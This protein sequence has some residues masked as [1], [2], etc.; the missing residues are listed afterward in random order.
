MNDQKR[1]RIRALCAC[2]LAGVATLPLFAIGTTRPDDASRLIRAVE[3]DHIDTVR[4]LV[5]QGIDINARVDGDGT[6]LIAA[7]R[8]GDLMMVDTLIWMGADVNEPSVGDGNPLIA[9]AKNGHLAVAARLIAA[10]ALID[11]IV[12]DD[13]TALINAVRCSC[14]AV[15]KYLVAHGADVNLGVMADGLR[16]RTPLN[17][18]RDMTIRNFLIGSGAVFQNPPPTA[19]RTK[20][21]GSL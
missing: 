5:S 2:T 18:A 21:V 4:L 11:A 19:T 12:P 14:L 15:V 3:T 7:A 16:W 1:D 20:S 6:A 13:E 9:A 10:G 8:R 17:Q